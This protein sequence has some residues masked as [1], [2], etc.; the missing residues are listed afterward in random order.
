MS[1]SQEK[2]IVFRAYDTAVEANLAKTKLDAYG[3]PCFLTDENFVNLYPIR[4][5]IFPGVRLYI[6]EKDY[7][8]VVNLLDNPEASSP[9]S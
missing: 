9:I 7:D 8:E 1:E 3:F 4:N 6:F 2:I 5:D